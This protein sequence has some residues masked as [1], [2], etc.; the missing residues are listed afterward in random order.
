MASLR[1]RCQS[2]FANSFIIGDEHL[3]IKSLEKFS[4]LSFPA[5]HAALKP[6]P[7]IPM[8]LPCLPVN[9][10]DTVISSHSQCYQELRGAQI[11]RI[12]K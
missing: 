11:H 9:S 6:P 1:L 8:F 5:P 7:V 4:G 2:L 3:I 12:I 10:P